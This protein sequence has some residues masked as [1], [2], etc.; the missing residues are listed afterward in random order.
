MLWFRDTFTGL[1]QYISQAS[2]R[3]TNRE[4]RLGSSY[5]DYYPGTISLS[6]VTATQDG[7]AVDFIFMSGYQD[8][9]SSMTTGG[10]VTKEFNPSLTKPPLKFNGCLVELG[11]ISLIKYATGDML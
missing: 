7:T 3:R 1:V 2:I 6:Q 8:D 5:W 9:S 10:L 4:C 11:L